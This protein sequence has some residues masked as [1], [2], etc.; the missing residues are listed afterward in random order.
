MRAY[1]LKVSISQFP[2]GCTLPEPSED[3]SSEERLAHVCFN[4]LRVMLR[5]EGDTPGPW[6]ANHGPAVAG[7]ARSQITLHTS[8]QLGSVSSLYLLGSA[9]DRTVLLPFACYL[10][11]LC[12]LVR[13]GLPAVSRQLIIARVTPEISALCSFSFCGIYLCRISIETSVSMK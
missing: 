3:W 7:S 6:C 1:L 13:L 8:L 2:W 12:A 5:E 10:C 9:C 4:T 11:I